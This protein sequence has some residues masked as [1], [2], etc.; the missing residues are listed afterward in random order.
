MVEE[1][2]L[3]AVQQWLAS[4]AAADLARRAIIALVIVGAAFV[5]ARLLRLGLDRMRRRF[6]P[7]G[8]F[9]YIVEQVGA[10]TIMLV[11]VLAAVTT[12][13]VNL[14]SLTIFGGAVGVGVGLGLQ[15]I[16]KDFV[17]GLVLIFDPNLQVG[18]FVE[19]DGVRGEVVEFGARATRLRT[20]DDLNVVIPNS[21]MIQ[22]RVINWTFNEASRRIH[23]P[24]SVAENSE[25]ARVREVVIAAARALSFTLPD[26]HLRKTQ[27]WLTNF[28]GAGLE[29]DLVV[30]PS[31]ESSR[32]PRTMHAAY[33]WA[34]YM[35][36]REAGIKN[37]N[38]QM[39][40]RVQSLFGREGEAAFGALDSARQAPR[41]DIAPT[42]APNDAAQAM[43][44]DVDRDRLSRSE[45]R[46]KRERREA[47]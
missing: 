43:F 41:Q 29:F 28:S 35:A 4:P 16:V 34:I 31:L 22:S 9:I 33:T 12:L 45:E 24:F 39:D 47:P 13:G 6:T 42:R 5:L 46:G 2:I 23:V 11:G 30:W 44:D 18:D 32:H 17:S 8:P 20:N 36:L 25:A 26:D 21:T 19:V 1:S 37:A 7:G 40:I 10:Y 38:D 27:V 3:Y 15:G 14:N